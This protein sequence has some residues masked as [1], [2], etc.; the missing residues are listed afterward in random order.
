MVEISRWALINPQG[1]IDA[2]QDLATGALPTGPVA[3]NID[4]IRA[5]PIT[6]PTWLCVPSGFPITTAWTWTGTDFAQP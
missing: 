2:V 3:A 4:V 6:T 1:T 5:N